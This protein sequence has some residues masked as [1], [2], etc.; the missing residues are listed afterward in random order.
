MRKLH[1]ILFYLLCLCFST[2]K[3]QEQKPNVVLFFV[4]DM[5]WQDTSVPFWT[6]ETKFNKR[7]HTPNMER[8]AKKGT[9]FTQAYASPICSPSRV[10]ILTGSNAA[11][12]RVTNWTLNKNESKDAADEHLEFPQ[13]NMNG[14]SNN[15]D[16]PN[17]FVANTLPE[18]LKR[19]GYYTIH[20]GKAHLGAKNTPGEDPL[21]LGFD[22]NIAGHAAGA[23]ESFLGMENFGNG[24]PG[25]SEWAVPGLEKYHGKNIFL[26]EAI[27]REALKSVDKVAGR[28]PFLLYM[29][30]YAVHVPIMPDN[31]FYQKYLTAG[32][33]E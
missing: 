19:N 10:S 8:L 9:K 18:L 25:K 14:I 27:T 23:P 33:E 13:W 21:N 12:H 32:L 28:K 17:S 16:V 30:H 7:Y 24:K 29:S 31:R 11:R 26:T 20:A 22:E 1:S 5:G 3:S 4:D 15:E 6:Q 2:V